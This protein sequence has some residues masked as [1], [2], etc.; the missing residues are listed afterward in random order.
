[1]SMNLVRM[2]VI[3]PWI[4]PKS[5]RF[6]AHLNR[7]PYDNKFLSLCAS[8]TNQE[9]VYDVFRGDMIFFISTG[10]QR[11]CW[12]S[13]SSPSFRR[14][15]PFAIVH[16]VSPS[17]SSSTLAPALPRG[18]V[19]IR[20]VSPHSR[21]S[22]PRFRVHSLFICRRQMA[23]PEQD[24]RSTPSSCAG[25][26][27]GA[28]RCL[29]VEDMAAAFA[30]Y[31]Y[32]PPPIRLCLIQIRRPLTIWRLPLQTII[33]LFVKALHIQH[34]PGPPPSVRLLLPSGSSPSPSIDVSVSPAHTVYADLPP[35]LAAH[36][37]V[38][39]SGPSRPRPSE[40]TSPS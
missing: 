7:A 28:G 27:L 22:P 10:S 40:G 36:L 1:M 30:E 32:P 9:A 19:F 34:H 35:R 3:P 33:S 18:F 14:I 31:V 29:L 38:Y 17:S 25:A 20:Y 5:P 13:T 37:Y 24:T 6:Q 11:T 12:N 21:A 39:I 4:R 16:N 8:N 26:G 23:Y 2:S 15:V